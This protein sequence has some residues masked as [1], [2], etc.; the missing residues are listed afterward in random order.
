MLKK[1]YLSGAEKRKRKDKQ[2]QSTSKL[3]K[4][5]GFL[6]NTTSCEY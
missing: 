1:K 6:K 5:T 4:I 2:N 3:P